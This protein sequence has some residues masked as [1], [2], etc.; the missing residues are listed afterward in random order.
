MPKLNAKWNLTICYETLS[1]IDKIDW[2][3]F[4]FATDVYSVLSHLLTCV[5]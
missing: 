3:F 4:S 2:V 5:L 1:K